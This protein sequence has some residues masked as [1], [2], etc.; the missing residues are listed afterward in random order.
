MRTIF[1]RGRRIYKFFPEKQETIVAN[2]QKKEDV[3]QSTKPWIN[4][5]VK[6]SLNFSLEFPRW[7]W[8]LFLGVILAFLF[9]W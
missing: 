8:M 2:D 6:W 9:L 3:V 5:D 4:Q 1:N 7:C